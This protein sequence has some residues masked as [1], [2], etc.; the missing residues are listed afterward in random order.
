[1]NKN[2]NVVIHRLRLK[3]KEL[4]EQK[5]GPTFAELCKNNINEPL[6]SVVLDHVK[7]KD[8]PDQARRYSLE[9][10]RFALSIQYVSPKAMRLLRSNFKICLPSPSTVFRVTANW[11][12]DIG[13]NHQM[14]D[15]LKAATSSFQGA[16]RAVVLTLD[17]MSIDPD[18]LYDR[19][20]DSVLGLGPENAKGFKVAKHALVFMVS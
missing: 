13:F 17:E 3:N 2:K 7:N 18:V 9:T 20:S 19:K 16:E 4:E 12:M 6:L 1:M 11:N 15:G 8:K 10:K 14:I 5:R